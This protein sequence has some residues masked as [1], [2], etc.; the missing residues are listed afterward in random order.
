[1]TSEVPRRRRRR[2]QEPPPPPNNN[3]KIALGGVIT[4]IVIAIIVAVWV[5]NGGNE[6]PTPSLPSVVGENQGSVLGNADA[7]VAIKDFSDFRCP[8][9]RDAALNLTPKIVEN[10]IN[11][12]GRVSFEFVPVSVLGDESML[13]AQAS[14]CA[15]DQSQFWAYHDKL[16]EQQSSDRF[17]MA[18]LEDY[19]GDLGLDEQTFRDCMLSGKHRLTIEKNNDAFREAGARGTPSFLIGE[20][21]VGGAVAFSEMQ[22][23]IDAQLDK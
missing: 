20:E 4:A 14:M 21:L 1:M 6:P 9:C 16:F 18:T 7:A 8:H 3:R 17:D 22:I 19:A 2:G 15:E 5:G 12:E 10:Y 23:I 13:A 11:D